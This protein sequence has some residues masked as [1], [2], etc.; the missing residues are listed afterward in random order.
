MK[1][2][3]IIDIFFLKKL[4]VLNRWKNIFIW[5]SCEFKQEFFLKQLSISNE[6]IKTLL[7]VSCLVN[8]WKTNWQNYHLLSQW[9]TS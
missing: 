3:H 6:P 7:W 4:S 8:Q 9:S 5:N 2:E 1:I